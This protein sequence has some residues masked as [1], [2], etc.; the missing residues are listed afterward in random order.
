MPLEE[1]A[2]KR[3]GSLEKFNEM[4][5]RWVVFLSIISHQVY[6]TYFCIQLQIQVQIET[7]NVIC[8][9]FFSF[10]KENFIYPCIAQ[11]H[12]LYRAKEKGG[13]NQANGRGESKNVQ[14]RAGA[15]CFWPL[16]AGAA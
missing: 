4:L 13:L 1:I 9:S 5:N 14:S 8:V 2:A 11:K 3:W 10:L 7:Q 16:R 15:A 6:F 12:I